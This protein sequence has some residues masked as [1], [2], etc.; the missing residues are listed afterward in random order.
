MLNL[1]VVDRVDREKLSDVLTY[2]S[3][4]SLTLALK[5]LY[6]Y[7]LNSIKLMRKPSLTKKNR[8]A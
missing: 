3:G 7:K 1:V 5:I 6:K 2:K 4:I 8:I